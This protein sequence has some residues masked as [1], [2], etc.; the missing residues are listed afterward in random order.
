MEILTTSQRYYRTSLLL[1]TTAF[2]S[3]ACSLTYEIV[4]TRM[5][6]LLFGNTTYAVSTVLTVFMGGM[7]LGSFIAGKF[8]TVRRN[9]LLIYAALEGMIGLYAFL[10]PWWFQGVQRLYIESARLFPAFFPLLMVKFLLAFLLLII[11][12]TFIGAT[13][14]L[15]SHYLATYWKTFGKGIGNL[16]A[17][18]TAGAMVG[19]LAPAFF[20][21]HT[22]GV[23][24]TMFLAASGNLILSGAVFFLDRIERRNHGERFTMQYTRWPGPLASVSGIALWVSALSGFTSLAYEVIWTRTFPFSLGNTIYA[25]SLI[26]VI[27][28]LGLALGSSLFARF[29]DKYESN[30]LVILSFAQIFLGLSA[31]A[32]LFLLKYFASTANPLLILQWEREFLG[33]KF[34]QTLAVMIV[35]TLLLGGTF[36]VVLK[37][38][39]V[40]PQT[41]GREVGVIYAMNTLGGIVGAFLTGFFFIPSIGL[42]WSGRLM[43]FLNLLAG[44]VIFASNSAHSS[45]VVT[46]RAATI[47]ITLFL[48]ITFLI[49]ILSPTG[50][51]RRRDA[52]N[53]RSLFYSEGVEATVEVRER[54]DGKKLLS[55]N[56]FLVAGTLDRWIP[57]QK[58][59]GHFPMLLHPNP[60]DVLVIG[61]GTGGTVWAISQHD[62]ER[63]DCAELV[64]DVIEAAAYFP[65]VNHQVIRNPKVHLF[66]DD[67]R[68]YLLVADHQY[69][70]MSI[71]ATSPKSAGSGNL[72]TMEFYELTKKRLK[73]DG[74]VAQWLPYHLLSERELKIILKTFQRVYPHVTLWYSQGLHYLILI[75]TQKSLSIDFARF[76]ERVESEKVR[77]DLKE[78]MMNN[79][80]LLLRSFAMDEKGIA[81]FAMREEMVN[82]YDRPPIEFFHRSN[83]EIGR[84]PFEQRNGRPRV[85][86]MNAQEE[87]E[88]ER[89][90]TIANQ[91]I[92]AKFY[93][94][95]DLRR[96]DEEYETILRKYPEEEAMVR[97]AREF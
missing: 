67:G 15:L 11:P 34:F 16:Y 18:N 30:L 56:G 77:R 27:F 73:D 36:P 64:P 17:I 79:R 5:L 70:V 13:F 25:F 71:D 75:G 50:T 88:L 33:I 66:K 12:T 55:I 54:A 44:G 41:P 52:L 42:E 93:Q 26:L 3:G 96:S 94:D 84:F 29:I 68:N 85:V 58:L 74:V 46:S 92:L 22:I 31:F 24:G 38:Y 76:S 7:A 63:I 97:F 89:H 45:R 80:D 20:L 40:S 78:I 8:L 39:T 21:F 69:D 83:G 1:L 48:G 53:D 61:L 82:T 19:A 90:L 47:G 35:P 65:E 14:P 81:S 10:T 6:T 2:L 87:E 59:L 51:W 49:L 86:N 43:V 57:I 95:R 62:P 28:L 60:K 37:L 23:Q 91:F 32:S 9:L 4:W 72:Y